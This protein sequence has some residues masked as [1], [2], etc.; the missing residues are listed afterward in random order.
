MDVIGLDDEGAMN[1]VED[2]DDQTMVGILIC[3]V[4]LFIHTT[5]ILLLLT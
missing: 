1:I 5:F 4:A 2:E 3:P